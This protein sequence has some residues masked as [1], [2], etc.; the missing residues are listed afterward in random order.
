MQHCSACRV[1]QVYRWSRPSSTA[2]I[3]KA[4]PT[5]TWSEIE[6]RTSLLSARLR[7]GTGLIAVLRSLVVI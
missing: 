6:A 2:G 3:R 5:L 1:Q 4:K 7:S